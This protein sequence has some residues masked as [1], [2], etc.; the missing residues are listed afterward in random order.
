MPAPGY[1]WTA[2]ARFLAGLT[3]VVTVTVFVALV[4]SALLWLI[5]PAVGGAR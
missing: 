1:R 4:C 3:V 2:R 5:W